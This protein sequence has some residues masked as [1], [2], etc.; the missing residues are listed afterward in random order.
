MLL[1]VV[2]SHCVSDWH[3]AGNVLELHD[4]MCRQQARRGKKSMST[5]CNDGVQ[6]SFMHALS[7]MMRQPG[8]NVVGSALCGWIC[9]VHAQK[10]NACDHSVGRSQFIYGLWT[11]KLPEL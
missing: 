10:R 8:A 7:G 9:V 1:P 3:Q 6:M 4:L 11:Y 5:C 2:T